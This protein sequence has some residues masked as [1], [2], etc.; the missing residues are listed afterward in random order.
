MELS[1]NLDNLKALLSQLHAQI[2]AYP[3]EDVLAFCAISVVALFLIHLHLRLSRVENLKTIKDFLNEK[4]VL[5]KRAKVSKKN[6][7]KNV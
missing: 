5:K 2:L 7:K 6:G 1:F 4:K 3:A